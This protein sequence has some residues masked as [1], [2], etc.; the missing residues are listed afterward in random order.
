MSETTALGAAMAAAVG[1]GLINAD[2]IRYTYTC[3]K[4]FGIKLFILILLT[5]IYNYSSNMSKSER[6]EPILSELEA[7]ERIKLWNAAVEKSLNSV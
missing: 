4:L 3:I 5:L 2:E 1:S 6:Y 7:G